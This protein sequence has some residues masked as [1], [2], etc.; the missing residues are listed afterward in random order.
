[1]KNLTK[2]LAVACTLFFGI[3]G[4]ISAH[5]TTTLSHP[6]KGCHFFANNNNITPI[7]AKSVNAPSL[8]DPFPYMILQLAMDDV[9]TD[10][11]MFKFNDTAKMTY[12]FNEDSKYFQ[13]FGKVSLYSFSQDSIPLAINGL[14]LPK[15]AADVIRLNVSAKASG[16]YQLNMKTIS[17]IPELFEVWLM[18]NYKNDSLDM[19]K[20]SSYSFA[21][22]KSISASY[23]GDR[24]TLVI[25]QQPAKYHLTDFAATKI[26]NGQQVQL[27][28]TAENEQGNTSFTL[29]R[30]SNGDKSFI[31]IGHLLSSGRGEYI[32]VDK[33]PETGENRY[34]LKQT[35]GNDTASYSKI[36]TVYYTSLETNARSAISIYPNPANNVINVSFASR[37]IDVVAYRVEITNSAGSTVKRVYSS[38]LQWQGN[39]NGLRPGIYIVHVLNN[40]TNALIGRSKF[41]KL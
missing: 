39:V 41:M 36:V 12:V 32:L 16:V 4:N 29:E 21:I 6:A 18:D 7:A 27:N 14:P 30:S 15:Q 8:P 1:M 10:G 3:I 17:D 34:R 37:N 5:S 35:P 11:I 20:V 9:N 33:S 25:R 13:G 22:D 40:A 28:W 26:T 24:F 23:G 2:I 38:D 31:T 19:R